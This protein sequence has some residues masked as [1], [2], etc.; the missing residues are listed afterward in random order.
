MKVKQG[1]VVREI[2][3]TILAV[4]TG[5]ILKEHKGLITLNKSG[6]FIWELLE[7]EITVEELIK[8]VIE[9]YHV[10]EERATESVQKFIG[11]LRDMKVIIE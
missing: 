10:S 1:F 8:K 7:N 5:E 2:A 11:S 4:P 3:D 9:K 6:K